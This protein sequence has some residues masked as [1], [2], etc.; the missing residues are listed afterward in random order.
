MRYNLSVFR[1]HRIR[2]ENSPRYRVERQRQL[3]GFDEA[4]LELRIAKGIRL[5]AARA[6]LDEAAEWYELCVSF[7]RVFAR[8]DDETGDRCE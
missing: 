2:Y 8:T 5:R 6:Y 3:E 1:P 7:R 4:R